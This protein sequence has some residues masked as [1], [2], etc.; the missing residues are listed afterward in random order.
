MKI[1]QTSD[2]LHRCW[3]CTA[4]EQYI[5]YHDDDWGVP[6]ADDRTLFEKITLESFQS[7]LSWRTIL[8][9]R[10]G[11]R[12]GFANFDIATVAQFGEAD[13]DRLLNDK[14]I[15]RHRGK[16]TATI[17]NANRALEAIAA[18]GSLATFFWS[19]ADPND[20]GSGT[21]QRGT[22]PAATAMSK[23]MKK[24]GWKFVGPT[25]AYAF[26]QAAGMVND[27]AEGCH[28]RAFSAAAIAGF[29]RP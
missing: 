5:A 27:H 16:I 10:D 7:G 17:N 25:T 4:T 1:E 15:V 3:W 13:V 11:F 23:V 28:H 22:S 6:T 20:L 29:T 9:K 26:M 2:G 19:F 8:E 14:G 21:V 12:H 18:H 24:L